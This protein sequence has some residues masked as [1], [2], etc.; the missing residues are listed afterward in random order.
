MAPR[1]VVHLLL[2]TLK[3][4]C[5]GLEQTAKK[6]QT[7]WKRAERAGGRRGG[8]LEAG[9]YGCKEVYVKHRWCS[10]SANPTIRDVADGDTG[11]HAAD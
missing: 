9:V 6:S 5:C 4:L 1:E 11:R 10:P 8:E 2:D 3:K 7:K